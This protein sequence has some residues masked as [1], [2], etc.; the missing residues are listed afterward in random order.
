MQHTV[1]PTFSAPPAVIVMLPPA[2]T[3]PATCTMPE[4]PPSSTISPLRSTSAFAR[5]MPE[6]LRTVLSSA[7]ALFAFRRTVPPSATML[8]VLTSEALNAAW[9]TLMLTRPSPIMSREMRS[10]AP[11][12]TLPELATITPSLR[13]C[14]PIKAV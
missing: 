1:L 8:P 11:S 2:C 4:P 7:F 3:V 12:A 10:P 9:S 5:T 6:V 14:G 13:T